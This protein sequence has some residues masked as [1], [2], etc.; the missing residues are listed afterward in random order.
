MSANSVKS[1]YE[2]EWKAYARKRI[3]DP[4]G[5]F[6]LQIAGLVGTGKSVLDIGC[7][8]GKCLLPLCNS[9]NAALGIDISAEAVRVCQEC[10]LDAYEFD[11]EDQPIE[12]LR[13]KGPFDFVI[14]T[15]VLEHLID[16]FIVLRDKV[17]PLL[18]P[19]GVCI[20]TVPNFVFLK[21]RW[22]LLLG[23]ISHFGND[24]DFLSQSPPR[25]YNLGHKTFFNRANLFQTF[26]LAGFDNIS[27]EPELFSP[28]LKR[29]WTLPFVSQA[30]D[31]LKCL[32]PT[33]LAARFLVCARR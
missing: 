1:I 30:R 8:A 15:D 2:H 32:W 31:S 21:Y 18:K 6:G 28:S 22:E 14:M 5:N 27:V 23:N 29:F 16:P 9:G 7:G 13:K 10:G 33:L 25:P 19:G 11:I 24:G 4:L 26:I 20:A 12:E 3:P 17:H